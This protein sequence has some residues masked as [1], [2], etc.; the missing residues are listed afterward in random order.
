MFSTE[1]S[2]ASGPDGETQAAIGEETLNKGGPLFT[3]TWEL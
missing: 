2:G 3:C 1:M